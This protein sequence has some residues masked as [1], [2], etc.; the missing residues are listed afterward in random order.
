MWSSDSITFG[1]AS[2]KNGSAAWFFFPNSNSNQ[3]VS[4]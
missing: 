3:A 4:V 2:K 1:P